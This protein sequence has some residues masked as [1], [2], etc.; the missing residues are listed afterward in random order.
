[1]HA[2]YTDLSNNV[3]DDAPVTVV[4]HVPEVQEQLK[5][6]AFLVHA[7]EDEGDE[8]HLRQAVVAPGPVRR[9]DEVHLRRRASITV[10]KYPGRGLA[11]KSCTS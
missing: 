6:D 8:G 2:L 7:L 1:M 9:R 3:S 11:R 4:R 5:A 10:Y